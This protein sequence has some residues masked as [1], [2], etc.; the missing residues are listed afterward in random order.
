VTVHGEYFWLTSFAFGPRGVIYADELPGNG[1]FERHQ[2][3]I[4]VT[5]GHVQ[6]LW[7]EG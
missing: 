4:S 6:L 7:Q 5:A 1:G 3:L 2:Q